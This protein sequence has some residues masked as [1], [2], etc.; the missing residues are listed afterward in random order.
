MREKAV[1][2]LIADPIHADALSLLKDSG[3]CITRADSKPKEDLTKSA[4][5]HHALIC[6]T[7]TRLD[8]NFFEAS[9]N[10]KCVGLASTGYDHIDIEE[11]SRRGVYVF[12]LPP[13]NKKINV[14]KSGNFISTAEHTI[15]L[16]LAAAGNFYQAVGSLKQGRWEKSSL[17]GTELNGKTLGIIGLGRIGK[18]VGER[19]S[20]LGMKIIA[21]D[22]YLSSEQAAE[23]N[24][25]LVSLAMLC[26]K[27]DVITIH[28]PQTPQT[29]NL[30]DKKCFALMK[31]GVIIVNAA[32]ASIIYEDALLK[33]LKNG[34]VRS[35]ALDV[36]KNEP[37]SYPSELMGMP[38]VIATP[39]I[40]GSTEEALRR[41]SMDTAKNIISYLKFGRVKNAINKLS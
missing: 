23:H 10:L 1:K 25:K 39:H 20:G 26:K 37:I 9:K 29:I 30:V 33:N 28:A 19:A 36:F 24:A 32:R 18:L 40:G 16:M 6:R 4:R 3:F 12:G 2:I 13:E 34:R 14:Y 17:V 38:N 5:G 22:P 41:I 27:A 7:A 31:P 8:K 35:A 15:L 21:Y 11:A